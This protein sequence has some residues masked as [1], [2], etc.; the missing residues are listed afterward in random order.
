MPQKIANASR[1]RRQMKSKSPG[2]GP[3]EQ[4]VVKKKK[5]LKD[6]SFPRGGNVKTSIE[7]KDQPSAQ[8]VANPEAQLFKVKMSYK[9]TQLES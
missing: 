6:D 9:I 1:K 5:I 2:T 4:P 3:V 7:N 8:R